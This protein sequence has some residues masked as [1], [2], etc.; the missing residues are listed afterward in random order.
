MAFE[1]N[2]PQNV[3]DLAEHLSTEFSDPSNGH[4]DHKLILKDLA[5]GSI[6]GVVNVIS[7]HPME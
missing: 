5:A 4:L 2:Y 6:S 1:S 3:T 7:G